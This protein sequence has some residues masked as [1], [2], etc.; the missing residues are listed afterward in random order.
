[1][2][3]KNTVSR[4]LGGLATALIVSS[5]SLTALAAPQQ[6]PDGSTFDPEY[7]AATNPD[8]VAVLGNSAQMMWAHYTACGKAEGRLP[9]AGAAIA[10]VP[11][12]DA[13]YYA[14]KYPDVVAVLGKDPAILQRHYLACGKAEGRFANAAEEQAAAAAAAQAAQSSVSPAYSLL[15]MINGE[16]TGQ[17]VKPVEWGY[18]LEYP[19]SIRVRELTEHFDTYRLDGTS[20]RTVLD[21]EDIRYVESYELITRADTAAE[22]FAHWNDD[23][24]THSFMIKGCYTKAAVSSYQCGSYTYWDVILIEAK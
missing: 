1:M 6:M 7:Y 4:F 23:S 9:Y 11:G 17:G 14:T 21:K 24:F 19:T 22:A 5:S 2:R 12:F 13:A 15:L 20:F 10:A 8:V 3:L 16:R 18:D